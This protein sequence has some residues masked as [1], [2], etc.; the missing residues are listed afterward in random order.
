[1]S[2]R[3]A[4]RRWR[5]AV[6]LGI[7]ALAW[8]V[9]LVLVALLLPVY[10][11]SSAS[12]SDGVTLTHSTLVE[13]NGVRALVLMA[14]PAL[15]TV[16]VLCAV[17]ARRAGARWGGR[18]AWTAVGVLAAET[19]LGILTIGVF[20]LPVVIVLAVA[21]RLA[22]GPASAR[23]PAAPPAPAPRVPDGPSGEPL[24]GT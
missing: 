19:L 11:T 5:T 17:R 7:G 2:P 24:A 1:M 13:V 16:V 15:L 12:E 4:A 10:G 18:V 8:S 9:G 22:P 6:R 20:I 14:I 23:G 3:V 21:V